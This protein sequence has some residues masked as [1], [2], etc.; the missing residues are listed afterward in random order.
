MNT[1]IGQ[2]RPAGRFL[3]TPDLDNENLHEMFDEM[4]LRRR[5][6]H[7]HIANNYTLAAASV[8]VVNTEVPVEREK[9][10]VVRFSGR[11]RI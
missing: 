2:I 4:L 10:F 9:R 5:A 6:F 1:S 3:G 7:L 11:S 8:T